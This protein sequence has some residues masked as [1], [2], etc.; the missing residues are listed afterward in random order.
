MV[1]PQKSCIPPLSPTWLQDPWPLEFE[2]GG[3]RKKN[4]CPWDGAS[5]WAWLTLTL[6]DGCQ[7]GRTG[8]S[9]WLGLAGLSVG[10]PDGTAGG[11]QL[12]CN[13]FFPQENP[14]FPSKQREYLT[15]QLL[16]QVAKKKSSILF[17][18]H[19]FFFS[20]S[21]IWIGGG[22]VWGYGFSLFFFLS[23][24]A[25]HTTRPGRYLL[26]RSVPAAG[27]KNLSVGTLDSRW[28]FQS[29]CGSPS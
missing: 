12:H 27:K 13:F 17:A 11:P 18:S 5:G 6:A 14:L 4:T 22:E 2:E 1:S 9:P 7:Q 23:Q 28:E 29:A 8:K 15:G 3:G 20:L 16:P 26:A 21:F 24:R 25:V 10:H 19:F